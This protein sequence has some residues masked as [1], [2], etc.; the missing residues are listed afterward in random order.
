MAG[1][2]NGCGKILGNL[3]RMGGAGQGHQF[4]RGILQFVSDDLR[5]GKQRIRLD[6]LR[7]IHNDLVILN[8]G[9]RLP[10]STADKGRG[11]CKQQNLL[12]PAHLLHIFCKQDF[13][14]DHH[15][16]QIGMPAGGGK[17]VDLPFQCRPYRHL[18]A[19][20]A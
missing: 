4:H 20:Q 3:F 11:H 8:I 16:R 9:C 15:A 12:S 18:V 10:G 6:A 7:Y 17:F 2:D 14:R 19:A 5:H 1:R 13:I